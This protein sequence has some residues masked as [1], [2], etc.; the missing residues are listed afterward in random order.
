MFAQRGVNIPDSGPHPHHQ[1]QEQLTGDSDHTSK[2]TA[3]LQWQPPP[4]INLPPSFAATPHHETLPQHTALSPKASLQ[5][6]VPQIRDLHLHQ[7]I[8]GQGQEHILLK[9]P[10]RHRIQQ[11]WPTSTVETLKMPM[12][13]D[14]LQAGVTQEMGVQNMRL[15]ARSI[16]E[17]HQDLG[18][19]GT[20][21]ISRLQRPQWL[22]APRLPNL[23]NLLRLQLTDI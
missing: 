14:H 7:T 1:E 19:G 8:I 6:L 10:L 20:V 9:K 5:E 3:V 23:H 13:P 15:K 12:S 18:R 16:E 11:R 21:R 4:Q 22:T 17:H 2:S